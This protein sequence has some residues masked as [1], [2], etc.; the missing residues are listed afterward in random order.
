MATVALAACSPGS[1]STSS[2]EAPGYPRVVENCDREVSVSTP[3][4]RAVAINQPATELLLSLG[5]ADRIAAV[6]VSDQQV[7][8]HLR[9]EFDAVDK[10]QEEFPALER[11]LDLEPDLVY[12]TF[13]YAFTQDGIGDRDRFE[14]LGVPTY[15]SPSECGGQEA[16]RSSELSLEDLYAE[17]DDIATLFGIEEDGQELIGELRERADAASADLGLDDVSLAWWYSSTRAPYMAGCCGAPALM[18]RAVGAS[19]AFEDQRQLWPEIS[20]E[21]IAARDPDVLV[22]ADLERGD[23]GD[24]ADAKIAFLESDPITSQLTAV[25]NRRYIILGGTTMDPSIRNVDGIEQLA[26]GLR[27]LGFVQ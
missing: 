9:G 23:D 14:A 4:E 18:T 24:S 2:P 11:V 15:Q 10:F 25:Q 17:I 6:G 7:L 22:L 26:D 21:A 8:P 12:S 5:L 3:I 20:W 13:A 16:E 19:N 1:T 27:D